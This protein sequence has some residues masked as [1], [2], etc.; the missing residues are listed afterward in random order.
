MSLV[1]ALVLFVLFGALGAAGTHF[2][3]DAEKSEV[4]SYPLLV[5]GCIFVGLAGGV[6]LIVLAKGGLLL[7]DIL[8]FP[9][10]PGD[11]PPALYKLPEWY[12]T[13]GRFAD[14]LIEYEKIAKI[15]PRELAC[16]TGMLDVLVTHMGNVDAARKIARTGL[17]KLRDKE[18]QAQLRQ[19]YLTLTGEELKM[20]L[21]S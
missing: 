4:L 16:W 19:Y 1:K 2:G 7:I 10:E 8:M 11:P 18:N 17:R 20:S 9:G 3:W 6:F 13:E 14:A 21:W 15:H 5:I 12:L